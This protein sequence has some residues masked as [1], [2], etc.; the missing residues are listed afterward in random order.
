M[1]VLECQF[2]NKLEQ[3]K[4]FCSVGKVNMDVNKA[5]SKDLPIVGQANISFSRKTNSF[6]VSV[7]SYKMCKHV[8]YISK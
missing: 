1:D 7:E 4:T 5:Y 6:K 2:W 3:I 8:L